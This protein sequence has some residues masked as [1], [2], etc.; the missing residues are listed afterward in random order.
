MFSARAAGL[1]L[2]G[3]STVGCQ[4]PTPKAAA[5]VQPM[6]Q[7]AAA[8]LEQ[9]IRS[10]NPAS[11][12]GQVNAVDAPDRMVSVEGMSLDQIQKGNIVSILLSNDPG[13]SLQAVVIRKT[14]RFLQLS[15]PP[16]QPGQRE[17][18][19]GD[20]AIWIPG[21]GTVQPSTVEPADLRTPD[22]SPS[23]AL[24]TDTS[25][26]AAPA[27]EPGTEAK[28]GAAGTKAPPPSSDA[29]PAPPNEPAATV[30]Q[31]TA[32]PTAAP[33]AAV[34]ETAAP[35]TSSPRP[36]SSR[37]KNSSG[38]THAVTS[39]APEES[40]APASPAPASPAPASPAP[41][42][43]AAV[44]QADAPAA[45]PDQ[46]PAGKPAKAATASVASLTRLAQ[47]AGEIGVP[48]PPFLTAQGIGQ[49]FPFIGPDGI[50][51]ERPIGIV[52]FAGPNLNIQAG[53]GV[54]FVL[55]VKQGAAALTAF[56]GAKPVEG[57]PDAVDLNGTTFKRTAGSLIFSQTR[58]AVLGTEESDVSDPFKAEPA[59]G[60][61]VLQIRFDVKSLRDGNPEMFKSMLASAKDAAS[62]GTAQQIDPQAAIDFINTVNHVDLAVEQA[63]TDLTLKLAVAPLK[64]P[65]GGMSPKP[66]MPREVVARFDLSASPMQLMT[67]P[68]KA[69]GQIM[70]A[71]DNATKFTPAQQ[72]QM[73]QLFK[74]FSDTFLNADAISLGVAPHAEKTVVYFVEQHRQPVDLPAQ[75]KAFADEFNRTAPVMDNAAKGEKTS[76]KISDYTDQDGLKVTRI[77][78]FDN[79]K[80]QM[81][82][83]AT[84]KDNIVFLTASADAGHHLGAIVNLPPQGQMNALMSGTL[85]LGATVLAVE[86]I[87]GSP[88][89][90]MPAEQR[91]AIEDGARGQ[92]LSLSG[93]G[94]GDG[95]VFRLTVPQAVIKQTIQMAQGSQQNGPGAQLQSPV[96][97]QSAA[98]PGQA[99]R[100]DD[101]QPQVTPPPPAPTAEPRDRF[102]QPPG[103]GAGPAQ[104]PSTPAPPADLNK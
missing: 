82:F 49:Q 59:G 53:Q 10:A 9:S 86:Q 48:L 25:G 6:S 40:P 46:A 80:P 43:P 50:D 79:D 77:T 100:P 74:A 67:S 23:A 8:N 14:G 51:S 96:P 68:E 99:T 32:Q 17:P 87:P 47:V 84:E 37:A 104:T 89:A 97:P 21:G 38:A 24:S 39:A 2:L 95:M 93:G 1:F 66:G 26:S 101:V 65:A 90:S 44:A 61:S 42:S 20:P 76:V 18:R 81:Y 45:A 57:H 98:P 73:A 70:K 12:V 88:L 22:T 71:S 7:A 91:K 83:D 69:I 29:S 54:V 72:K 16:L 60:K 52:F 78:G 11:Q 92:M 34:P 3:A 35:D 36:S 27:N 30:P 64:T 33:G 102:S 103:R 58:E 31:T 55:P 94:E 13:N 56:E 85:D 41:A 28:S 15:Y 4:Q 63:G 5:P 75:L 19:D 62:A